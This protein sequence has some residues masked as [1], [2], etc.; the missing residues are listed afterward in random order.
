MKPVRIALIGCGFMGK[1]HSNAFVQVPHFFEG[2]PVP[3]RQVVCARH[4]DRATSF[5]D[6]WGYAHVASDW[7][8]VV[9][10]DDVD[11]VDICVPNH[12]H[13]EIAEAAAAAGKIIWC[14][15]PLAMNVDEAERMCRAVERTG[16][17]HMVWYNYRRVPAVTL[18]RQL[19]S[20]GRL[21]RVFHYRAK[22]LQDWTINP[23]VPQGGT[24]TWR[25]D[26][27]E[28]GSGVTG[29]LL[30]HCI[31]TALWLNGP[32]SAVS[33]MT[34]TFIKE[35]MHAVSGDRHEVKIDDAAA[36]LCRF[37]NGSLGVFEATRYARGTK[38]S[39]RWK[40]MVSRHPWPGTCTIYIVYRTL[41]M[42][43]RHESAVGE[44]SMS[45]IRTSPT[46]ATGGCLD[47]RLDMST[48]SYTNW[49]IFWGPWN[50]VNHFTPI[51]AT[52]SRRSVSATRSW[53]APANQP[54]SRFESGLCIHGCLRRGSRHAVGFSTKHRGTT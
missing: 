27:Q 36:F 5:A 25:L 43:M 40:S 3:V 41:T 33:A 14:E 8:S 4:R 12:L 39:T 50:A 44:V 7:R 26:A 53:K 13:A 9:E 6:R 18:A 51:S 23:D 22:F 37:E 42:P 10:R 34:E 11:A 19:I 28:A 2:V 20:E 16:V 1:A 45:V 31:D 38:H 48:L 46:W 52:H 49:L 17:P 54:G 24:A 15:K 30:A 32:I 29:D 47:C 21:G 35:R